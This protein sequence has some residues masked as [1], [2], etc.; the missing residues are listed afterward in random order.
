[1]LRAGL[2]SATL[3]GHPIDEVIDLAVRCGLEGIEW[4]ENHHLA[5]GDERQA[6]ETRLKCLDK[7]LEIA[8]YGSYYRLGQHMDFRPSLRSAKALGAKYVRIWAGKKPSLSVGPDEWDNLVREAKDAARQAEDLGLVVTTEWHKN[9]LTDRNESGLRLLQEVDSPA[10]KT[11]WQPT[12]ALGVPERCEGLDMI[13]PWLTNVHVYYWD[14][15]GR[16][17]LSWG[18]EDW[19]RYRSHISGDHWALLEFVKGDAIAQLEEDAKTLKEWLKE[20]K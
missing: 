4:S 9:T 14:E 16:E 13:G 17:P 10:F 3:K 2:V 8:S 20:G 12:M 7:G 5:K 15:K 19:A 11:F 1:M 6:K 18:K